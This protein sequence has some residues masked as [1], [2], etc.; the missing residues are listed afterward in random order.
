MKKVEDKGKFLFCD[1]NWVAMT[2]NEAHL[3]L[4]LL[5]RGDKTFVKHLVDSLKGK[6]FMQS[7]ALLIHYLDMYDDKIDQSEH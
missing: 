1:L 7:L 6:E 5:S 4:E 3:L 2:R